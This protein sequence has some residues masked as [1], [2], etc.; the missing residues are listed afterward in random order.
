MLLTWC[1]CN[2]CGSRE[3]NDNTPFTDGGPNSITDIGDVPNNRVLGPIGDHDALLMV[4]PGIIINDHVMQLEPDNALA[5]TAA[6]SNMDVPLSTALATPITEDAVPP[7]YSP[8]RPMEDV[9]HT[10]DVASDGSWIL[11]PAPRSTAGSSRS[12]SPTHI[13]SPASA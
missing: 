9:Q 4:L 2:E 6:S 11:L 13:N 12:N 3:V 7:P 5:P 1:N 8:T 10:T